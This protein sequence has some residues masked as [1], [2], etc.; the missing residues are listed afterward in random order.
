MNRMMAPRRNRSLFNQIMADPFDVFMGMPVH[1]AS[2]MIPALMRTD[3]TETDDG[4][5]LKVDLPGFSKDDVQAELKD[6]YLMISAETKKE[7]EDADDKGTV[8][9]KERFSGKCSRSFFVGEDVSQDD[10]KARFENGVL[11]F[12]IPKKQEQPKIEEKT[13]SIDIE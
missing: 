5:K 4:F 8:V 10:V 12:A 6:G 13:A 2:R 3:I 1:Q 11:T 9:R 7:S